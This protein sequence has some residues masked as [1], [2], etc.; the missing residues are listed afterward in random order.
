MA[1]LAGVATSVTAA[2]SPIG[3]TVAGPATAC[4]AMAGTAFAVAFGA[5]FLSGWRKVYARRAA[6]LTQAASATPSSIAAA[7]SEVA[8]AGNDANATTA[9][10]RNSQ[11]RSGTP[12]M[13]HIRG[14]PSDDW[15]DE[16][17]GRG[18]RSEKWSAKDDM[19]LQNHIREVKYGRRGS[20]ESVMKDTPVAWVILVDADKP[21][22]GV[23]TLQSS[24]VEVQNVLAFRHDDDA[25]HFANMLTKESGL[26]T[27]PR[28]WK[29]EDVTQFCRQRG[30]SVHFADTGSMLTPP[31][32]NYGVN[33]ELEQDRAFLEQMLRNSMN[34][35]SP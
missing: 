15:W 2:T 33:V 34:G 27:T 10:V 8:E 21:S 14:V 11:T 5:E 17:M 18:R 32:V 19:M 24:Q 30:F 6:A 22:E 29:T 4:L 16:Q 35:G 9:T 31:K 13:R 12:Y 1:A 23:Y 7:R 28:C 25:G 3:L 26:D 20:A